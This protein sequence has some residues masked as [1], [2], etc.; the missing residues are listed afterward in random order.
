MSPS[1]EQCL[2]R[3]SAPRSIRSARPQGTVM[4][5]KA[6]VEPGTL[7]P[8]TLLSIGGGDPF[9]EPRDVKTPRDPPSTR[10]PYPSGRRGTPTSEALETA[11]RTLD[12]PAC[13]AVA[14]LPSGLAAISAALL[15]VHKAGDHVLVTDSIYWPTRKFCDSVL[16]RYGI[17]TSYF[18]P[19]IGGDIAKLLT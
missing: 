8:D 13:A 2:E 15:S 16:T 4:N 1:S 9:A 19:S 7:K 10:R 11:I 14:L 6:S 3:C 17:T 18:D 12:G 5:K